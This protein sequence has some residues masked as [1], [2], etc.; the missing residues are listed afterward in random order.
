MSENPDANWSYLTGLAE[1]N[2]DGTGDRPDITVVHRGDSETILR[3]SFRE[4]QAMREHTAAHPIV[5]L[6]QS[7]RVDFTVEG[8]TSELRGGTAVRVDTRIPHALTAR[9][10]GA[11]TLILVHGR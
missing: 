10:D 11:A 5:V 6:G 8:V 7:G 3:L 1:T 2:S 4:G 9:T